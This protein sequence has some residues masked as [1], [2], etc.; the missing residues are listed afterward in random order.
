MRQATAHSLANFVARQAGTHGPEEEFVVVERVH[1]ITV[2]RVT[3]GHKQ[4]V[5]RGTRFRSVLV[6]DSG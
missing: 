4:G 1:N 2:G 6:I 3:N 5:E